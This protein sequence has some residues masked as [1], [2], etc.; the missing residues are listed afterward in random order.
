MQPFTSDTYQSSSAYFEVIKYIK[1]EFEIKTAVDKT[2]YLRS[3]K[4]KFT[5]SGNYFN[6][7]P[8][9][10]KEIAYTVFTD[11]Y[12]EVEKA[13]YNKNFNV[14]SLGGM[15]EGGA[16]GEYYGS[17]YKTGVVTLNENGEAILEVNPDDKSLL[18]QKITLLAKVTDK[19]NNDIVSA[20]NTIV[21]AGEFTIFF[22]PSAEKYVLGEEVIAPFYAESLEGGK[23]RDTSFSYKLVEYNNNYDNQQTVIASG[24]VTSDEKGKGIVKF[25]L[26]KDKKPGGKQLILSAT[27]EKNNVI[28]NQKYLTFVTD[29]DKEP[30]Y[31]AR[32]GNRI[33]QTYLKISSN[34]NSFKV[35]DTVQLTVDSPKE[36]D[37]LLTFERGRVYAP[38]Y[39]H[40]NKG[41]NSLDFKVNEDLSPSITVVFSFFAEG[42]Y[43]TEGLSLNVPAMHKL[44]QINVTPNKKLY[45]PDE[46]AELLITTKDANGTPVAA[47]MSVGIVDKAIYTLRKSATKP[48]HSSFYYF[49]PR[50]TNASSSLTGMGDQGG[51]GGRGGGGGGGSQGSNADILYWNP[52][53]RTDATGET[54]IPVSLLGHKT[55]WKVQI[56]GNTIN[57]DVGQ[58]DA[59]FVVDSEVKG[60]KTKSKNNY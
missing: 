53:L 24:T 54:R 4:M 2:D 15:C 28:Q 55:T 7:K 20:S 59:E 46:T 11:N 43:H 21:H 14:T 50:R 32:W 49:R 5:I 36:M 1:P 56:M 44:L 27:D 18:S 34:Q 60:V 57:N 29:E 9:Q 31:V 8:L 38:G 26:P 30:T 25:T 41:S 45:S 47:Q 35:N 58:A 6:G 33:S 23:K 42:S 3:D 16:F 22:I 51:A 37:V 48:I 12:Y 19:N 13:V 39:I 17:E 52:N 40:L 10:N